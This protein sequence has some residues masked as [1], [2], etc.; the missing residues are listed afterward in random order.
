M[1]KIRE[2]IVDDD[3]YTR[4]VFENVAPEINEGRYP[5]KRTVGE[6]VCVEADIYADG[7][8]VIS[9]VLLYRWSGEKKWR[10]RS[11][12]HVVNDRWQGVFRVE[13]TGEYIYS[14]KGW[15]DPFRTWQQNLSKKAAA[16]LDI[17][18]ELKIGAALIKETALRAEDADRK[19]LESRARLLKTSKNPQDAA[20][21]ALNSEW[22]ALMDKYPP[23]KGV[24]VYERELTVSVERN[25]ALFSSWYEFFPRSFGEKPHQHGTLKSSRALLPE[26]AEMGFD[27][28]YL[29]PIHPIGRTHRKG[30][31]NQPRAEPGDPGSPW[32]IGSAEG[33]H[34]S[35]H[36]ELGTMADFEEF[37]ATAEKAGL[38]VALDLAFQCSPDHPYVKEH[39]EWFLWRPDGTV[40]FA[41]NPPKKY[42]DIIPLYFETENKYALW[43]E[44][45]S[46]TLFWADKGVRIFRVDNPHT[47][48]FAFW[49][50]L[51]REVKTVHPDVL[52]L[53][54]AFTRP[55]VMYRLA[56]LGFSQSYTYFTWRNS[57]WEIQEY[58]KE[59]TQTPVRE[60]FR[61]HFWPN[62]PDILPESLQYGGRP[63]FIAR[64]TLA[65]T[66][67]SN[68][69]IYGP[70][71][72][73]TEAQARPGT[74]EYLYSEKYEIKAWDRHR[75]D[76]LRE[77]VSRINHVRRHN[78][79]LQTT[80][81]LRFF[82]C[83][84][85]YLLCYG[86]TTS[87]L[88][89]FILVVVNLDPF[90][91]Q[92][93][94][95]HLPLEDLNIKPGQQFLVSDFLS[96]DKYFW[97]GHR[98]YVELN[99]HILPAH[100]FKVYRKMKREQDFDYFM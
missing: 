70:A 85:E 28:V 19:T 15:V 46:V 94:W 40:Q 30:K 39:P 14:L 10:E 86:K 56:K 79:A 13:K 72:E 41:E 4:V 76:S 18:V 1:S 3:R 84:N 20:A 49:E 81:N 44:L 5:V 53:A 33:G 63:A 50:W 12:R 93:G 26:I 21:S 36:P 52:F 23:E 45:K 97:Q 22:N 2:E 92:S 60:F 98:N 65:A 96:G 95:V 8:D 89:N 17:R 88:S 83:D 11:M 57:K 29:P 68:Y 16:G 6:T 32:A 59:L 71:F 90:H 31:N 42:E 73:V 100:I 43:E 64:L 54:E 25:R 74:E 51:I 61:P 77:I 82:E 47:K 66:L 87:D 35:I 80:R 34:K 37:V 7:H 55:K 67:S 38:E 91:A 9:A 75:P 62:T 69:G 48:P 99:P 78:P 58:L 24:S 27:V